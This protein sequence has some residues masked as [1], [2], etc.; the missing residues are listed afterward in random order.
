VPIDIIRNLDTFNLEIKLLKTKIDL[1][2]H[3]AD[4]PNYEKINVEQWIK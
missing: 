4:L 1:R 3:T 2:K